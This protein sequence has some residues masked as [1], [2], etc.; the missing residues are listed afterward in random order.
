MFCSKNG[1]A[2]KK[3]IVFSIIIFVIFIIAGMSLLGSLSERQESANEQLTEASNDL[4]RIMDKQIRECE[5]HHYAICRGELE[6]FQKNC[7][8]LDYPEKIPSCVDGR[9][10][11]YLSANTPSLYEQCEEWA[12]LAR[13]TTDPELEKYY[14]EKYFDLGCGDLPAQN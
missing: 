8:E 1:V 10:E 5:K 14:S 9:I 13:M 2:S 7:R 4:N 11:A 6:L 12:D 3:S